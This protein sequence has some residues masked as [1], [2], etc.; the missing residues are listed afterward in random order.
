MFCLL[1]LCGLKL[2]LQNDFWIIDTILTPVHKLL[3]NTRLSMV[4]FA[5]NC[6]QYGQI[7]VRP[8]CHKYCTTTQAQKTKEVQWMLNVIRFFWKKLLHFCLKKDLYNS[9]LCPK[10]LYLLLKFNFPIW[11]TEFMETKCTN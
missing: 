1:L 3:S 10:F 8:G 11:N 2:R 5:Y 4:T 7:S 6:F 9:K